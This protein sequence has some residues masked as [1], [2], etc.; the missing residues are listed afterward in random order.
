MQELPSE[1]AAPPLV[2]LTT[3]PWH[4]DIPTVIA[5]TIQTPCRRLQQ[6]A[7]AP[8]LTWRNDPL[9]G[10]LRAY[11]NKHAY[12]TATAAD[13]WADVAQSTGGMCLPL[14]S[15]WPS[16]ASLVTLPSASCSHP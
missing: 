6:A 15:I 13:L 10:A 3:T 16:A 4:N 9:L 7:A 12:G 14:F 1:T 2:T 8:T 11:L 5:C